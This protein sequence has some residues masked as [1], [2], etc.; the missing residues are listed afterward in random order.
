VKNGQ[1]DFSDAYA[2]GVGAWD[3]F[4][5]DWLYREFPKGTDEAT[6]LDAMARGTGQGIPLCRRW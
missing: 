1:L 3:R 2:K 6:A 5:I 4:A